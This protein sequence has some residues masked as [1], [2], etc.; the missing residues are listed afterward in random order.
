MLDIQ[1]IALR[2]IQ[3]PLREPFTI[4]SGTRTVR[5][6]LLAK[7]TEADGTSCWSEC[8]AADVPNYTSETIDTAWHAIQEWVAP[9]LLGR[10][11]QGPESVHAILQE[12]FRGHR[13]AK[14]T[15]EMG[16]WGLAACKENRPL[17]RLLGGRRSEIPTGVSIGIQGDPT[18]LVDKVAA[19]LEEGYR[20]IKLKIRPGADLAYVR[21][22]QDAFDLEDMLMVDANSAYSLD[23]IDLFRELDELG[24]LM[25]EQPLA[26]DDLARH[27]R[28][29]EQL[30]TPVCLDESVV[31]VE[32]AEDMVAF[33]SGRI[34]NIKPGRVGGLT[35]SK[36]IHDF[37]EEHQ[38]PVWCGGMLESGIGRAY[39]VALA[40]LPNFTLPGDVSPSH[41][42]WK[43]D[44]VTPEWTMSADG[45]V[46]VPDDEPGLG[47][48]VDEDR[49]EDLTVRQEVLEPALVPSDGRHF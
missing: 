13:M 45:M 4:S 15:I 3:L 5:R 35:S 43:Q 46:A 38:I 37:C 14:A 40:S 28:L 16:V 32:Q 18:A 22:V 12:H 24:L 10:S 6:L 30:D 36:A 42:Y 11:L 29:Q 17:A 34:I 9:R 41:R 44:I 31:S 27:A 48:T 7:L 20:K 47:V 33:G 2:E 26:W 1:K 39:N 19:H 21:A 49:V 23:D 25:I 8:V